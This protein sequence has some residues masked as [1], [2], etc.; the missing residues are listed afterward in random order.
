M[1]MVVASALS[2]E[3]D[4][5]ELTTR[6]EGLLSP[7]VARDFLWPSVSPEDIS[8]LRERTPPSVASRTSMRSGCGISRRS[9]LANH[10]VSSYG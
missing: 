8:G 7:Q 5:V 10:D 2:W 1:T 3:N 9:I 6:T 4:P